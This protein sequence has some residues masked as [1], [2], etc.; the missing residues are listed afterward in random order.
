MSGADGVLPLVATIGRPDDSLGR[1]SLVIGKIIDDAKLGIHSNDT[2]LQLPR[3]SNLRRGEVRWD[4]VRSLAYTKANWSKSDQRNACDG[5]GSN[6][7][8]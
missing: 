2:R 3:N 8:V 4:E 1:L 5:G 7:D 6:Y